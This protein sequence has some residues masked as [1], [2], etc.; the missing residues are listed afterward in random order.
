MSGSAIIKEAVSDGVNL[1]LSASGTIKVS[2]EKST[3]QRWAPIIKLHKPEIIAALAIND[4][5]IAPDLEQLIVWAGAYWEYSPDDYDLIRDLARHDPAGLRLALENDA[6]FGRWD[7][8]APA[9]TGR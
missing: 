9:I 8:T 4:T 2:G 1:T 3:V 6:A 5:P 7:K